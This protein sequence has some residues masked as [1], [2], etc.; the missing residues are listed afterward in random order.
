MKRLLAATAI[1]ITLASTTLGRDTYSKV[2][3]T[4]GSNGEDKIITPTWSGGGGFSPKLMV[5]T[6]SNIAAGDGVNVIF[7]IY[8]KDGKVKGATVAN[9]TDSVLITLRMDGDATNLSSSGQ[10]EFVH[11]GPFSDQ[12]NITAAPGAVWECTIW[13]R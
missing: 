2:F 8:L 5:L 9:A 13:G 6:A 10:Y 1:L 11:P 7:T 4:V 3:N 12:M